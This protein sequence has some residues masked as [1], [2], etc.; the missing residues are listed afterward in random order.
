MEKYNKYILTILSIILIILAIVFS[1]NEIFNNKNISDDTDVYVSSNNTQNLNNSNMNNNE[2]TEAIVTKV[3]DGDTLWVDIN[4]KSFKV[5]LIG[6]NCPEYT[7]E[8]EP[9]GK[10]ATDYTY[11]NL[12]GKTVYLMKDKTD[13]DDYDRLLRYVWTQ[14]V[15]DINEENV[16]NYLFNA[17]LVIEGL[18]QS[19]Y[20]K[21]NISLQEYLEKFERQAKEDKKG[22]WQ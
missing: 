2:F 10:E 9:D 20:Y 19:N 1:K 7:K 14:K 22:M 21:P 5:R 6:I 12:Y 17:K 13:T 16:A 8:I 15:D 4:E 11:N 3:V 18:A